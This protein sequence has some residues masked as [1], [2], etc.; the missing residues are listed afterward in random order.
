M[1]WQQNF[2][3]LTTG[4]RVRYTL[5]TRSGF[6]W[7]FVYFRGADRR[8]LERSTGCERKVD[9]IEAAHRLI[10]EEYGQVA[11]LAE[12]MPWETARAKLEEAMNADGKRSRTI[13]EYLKTLKHLAAMFPLAKGPADITDRMAGDFKTKY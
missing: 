6:P 10:L 8:R 9:A 7:Y 11:P 3:T 1:S 5:Q 12:R 2:V 13:S 4:D